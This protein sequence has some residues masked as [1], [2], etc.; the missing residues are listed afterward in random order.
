MRVS[1]EAGKPS[2][3]LLADCI[4]WLGSRG[5]EAFVARLQIDINRDR[6]RQRQQ[7]QP[8][9]R[10]DKSI[11]TIVPTKARHLHSV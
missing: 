2:P 4:L 10:L 7:N 6:S 5:V 9:R 8:Y 3:V 1:P 11:H